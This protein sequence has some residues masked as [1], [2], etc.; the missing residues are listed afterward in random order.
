[1]W[2]NYGKPKK[3]SWSW[4]SWLSIMYHV[5]TKINI[6]SLNNEDQHPRQ[7]HVTIITLLIKRAVVILAEKHWQI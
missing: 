6:P 2:F 5:H 1:M 3:Y 4:Q 7:H